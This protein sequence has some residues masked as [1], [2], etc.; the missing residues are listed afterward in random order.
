MRIAR[1]IE[2]YLL[3]QYNIMI[4]RPSKKYMERRGNIVINNL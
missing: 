4:V 1:I 3:F 2:L